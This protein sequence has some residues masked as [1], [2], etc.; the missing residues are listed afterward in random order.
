MSALVVMGTPHLSP[1]CRVKYT[2]SDAVYKLMYN[3]IINMPSQFHCMY[4]LRGRSRNFREGFPYHSQC[5]NFT[6][7]F[8]GNNK[9]LPSID[10]EKFYG[11]LIKNC[12]MK[13]VSGNP[14][15]PLKPPLSDYETN[16]FCGN[17][18]DIF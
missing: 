10:L 1:I 7:I 2:A 12:E 17:I 6:A 13:G 5:S 14:R 8:D 11:Q 15:N 4:R 9:F 18:Q 3:H 16:H